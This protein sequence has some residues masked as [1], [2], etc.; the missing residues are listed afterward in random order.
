LRS[1]F[2]RYATILTLEPCPRHWAVFENW[3]RFQN[4]HWIVKPYGNLLCET[5]SI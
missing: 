3:H 5:D 2:Q 1:C 4:N